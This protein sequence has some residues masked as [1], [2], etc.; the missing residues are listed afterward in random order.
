MTNLLAFF[1]LLFVFAQQ[2]QEKYS[3]IKHSFAKMIGQEVIAPNMPDFA[4]TI[5]Q[6]IENLDLANNIAIEANHEGVS[7]IF[8]GGLFFETLSSQLTT[9]AEQSLQQIATLLKKI[10]NHY[11]IDVSGHA[12]SRPVVSG[13]RYPS[14]W[15]LSAARAGSV[16]RYL[17]TQK[18]PT[19]RMRAIGYSD[20]Q[21]IS[22]KLD[23]NRRVVIQIGKGR[24]P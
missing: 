23:E 14:N 6:S 1:I 20:T 17:A 13:S 16:V 21:P 12:D 4:N 15:E 19:K 11:R 2:D 10:P 24:V 3:K 5:S 22:K 9:E 8:Q 7:L 18:I